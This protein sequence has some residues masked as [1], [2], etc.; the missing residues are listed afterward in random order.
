MTLNIDTIRKYPETGNIAINQQSTGVEK[1]A[2]HGMR[3]LFGPGDARVKNAETLTAIR[4]AILNDPRF[5]APDVQAE[6]KRLLSQGRADRAMDTAQIRGV[7]RAVDDL[8]PGTE[9]AVKAR[10]TAHLAAKMPTWAAGY[11]KTVADLMAQR[12]MVA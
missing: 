12:G 1:P 9:A 5:A 6:S 7:I 10:E 3:S 2:L 8:T 4:H 11:E